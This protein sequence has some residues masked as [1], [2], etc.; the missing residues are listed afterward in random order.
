MLFNLTL[1]V[2]LITLTTFLHIAATLLFK[3]LSRVYQQHTHHKLLKHPFQMLTFVM[4]ILF[5]TTFL[6]VFLWAACYL[7]IG[8]IEGIEPAIYFSMATFTTVGYGD[9]TLGA[10]WRVLSACEAVAGLI[11]FGWSSAIVVLTV[12]ALYIKESAAGRSHK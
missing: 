12:Q 8:A 6:Q 5:V 1:A 4:V 10:E 11:M 9:I 2:I 3:N 7:M